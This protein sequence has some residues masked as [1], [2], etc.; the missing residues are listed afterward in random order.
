MK[1]AYISGQITGLEPD[2]VEF[3]FTFGETEAKLRNLHPVNP[4]KLNHDHDKTWASY[5]IEDL[6]ALA[7]CQYILMLP[8]WTRSNGAKIEHQ[9]AIEAG[10][11]IIY[12]N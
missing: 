6:K 1:K 10:I 8:N 9:M 4:T 11:E 7:D 3:W 5:M 12:L 2:E